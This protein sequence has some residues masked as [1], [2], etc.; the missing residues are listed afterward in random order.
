MKCGPGLNSIKSTTCSR[1]SAGNGELFIWAIFKD[2]G[3]GGG[4][5]L[6]ACGTPSSLLPDGSG[7]YFPSPEDPVRFCRPRSPRDVSTVVPCFGLPRAWK[8]GWTESG[9]GEPMGSVPLS[10]RP[11]TALSTCPCSRSSKGTGNLQRGQE[12]DPATSELGQARAGSRS[13]A[14]GCSCTSL[15]PFMSLC[16]RLSLG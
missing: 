1:T 16:M 3:P 7:L 2:L 8:E 11:C 10:P 4:E 5:T 13:W 9:P 14:Y 6:S 15:P 12:P